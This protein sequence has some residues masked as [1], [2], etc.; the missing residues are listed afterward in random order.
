MQNKIINQ[1]D[2][3]IYKDKENIISGGYKINS[4]F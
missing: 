2:L 1:D 4:L 3:V